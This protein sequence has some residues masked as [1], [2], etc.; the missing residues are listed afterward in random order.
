MAGVFFFKGISQLNIWAKD[1]GGVSALRPNPGD[2]ISLFH[3]SN[4]EPVGL[5]NIVNVR[6]RIEDVRKV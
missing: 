4:N 5:N 3:I 2:K 6:H 1:C